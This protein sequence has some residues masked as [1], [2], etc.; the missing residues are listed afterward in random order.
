MRSSRR[1]GRVEQAAR[2]YHHGALREALID[3]AQQQIR[4][5]GVEKLSLAA[6][7]KA[8]GVS[9]AAPYKHFQDREALV[10][11]V[12]ARGFRAL[13]SAMRA[14]RDGLPLGDVEGLTAMARAYV[15]YFAAEPEMFHVMWGMTRDKVESE[16]A[17]EAGSEA[18][19][20][21]LECVRGIQ[22]ARGLTNYDARELAVPC[23][24]G[25]H[26][27]AA[28]KVGEKLRV[29]EG[30]DIDRAVEFATRAFFAG[31]EAMSRGAGGK[32]AETK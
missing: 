8:L 17:F 19:D 12:S 32:R 27:V 20:L 11:E 1:A 14:A 28:L 16:A 29:V 26:G 22:K 31:V 9:S 5:H 21:V 23:W 4:A 30:L 6:L 3:A 24:A 15:E 2:P 13:A 18:F 25:V 10:G 7:C